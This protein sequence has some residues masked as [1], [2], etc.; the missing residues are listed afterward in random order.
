LLINGDERLD[1]TIDE[2]LFGIG[3]DS[4]HI[5]MLSELTG[6]DKT[7]LSSIMFEYKD[8]NYVT[9]F[10]TG[11]LATWITP[12]KFGLLYFAISKAK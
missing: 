12:T 6:I 4:I 9:V 8:L 11:G 5:D 10:D 3:E 7:A 1:M 2:A